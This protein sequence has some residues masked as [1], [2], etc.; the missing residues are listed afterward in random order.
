[1]LEVYCNGVAV[2][3]KCFAPADRIE[4][5]A[6]SDGGEAGLTGLEGWKMKSMWE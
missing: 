5:F 6:F 3:H 4:V 1:V 2:T